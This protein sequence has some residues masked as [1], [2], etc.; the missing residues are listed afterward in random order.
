ML[1]LTD[2]TVMV[3]DGGSQN[4]ER[5]TPDAKGR[6]E[7][8]T[9]TALAPMSLA[10]LYF[11]S[12][13]LPS[14]K[15][16][17]LG[18]EYSGPGLPR[19][20]TNVAEI[21][22]PVANSWT[23]AAPYPNVPPGTCYEKI[24]YAGNTTSGSDVITGI[25]STARFQVGWAV[26]GP[27]IPAGATITSIDSPT[28]VHIS[29]NATATNAA[30]TLL[31]QGFEQSCFG[32]VPT[33][34]LPG[35][36]TILAGSL[37]DKSAYLYS[38]ASDSWAATGSKL[39]DKS[40]EEGYVLTS[41]GKVVTY[42]IFQS[43]A[44]GAGYAES[45]DPTTG[46]WSDISPGDGSA[47]G[48]LPLLSSAA[49]GDEFGPILR[50]QD[51]RIFAIGATNATAFYTAT[52][53]TWAA[54]PTITG[55]L[56]GNPAP[57]GADDAPGAILPNGHVLFAADA[58]PAA[59]TSTGNTTAGSNVITN[60]PSTALF[61]VGWNVTQTDGLSNVIPPNTTITSVDSPSQIHI[62]NNALTTNAGFGLKFGGTF[63]RPT[64]LFD[65]N[66]AGG[67]SISPV[68]PA[69]ADPVL[70]GE[71]SYN[72][73]M[74][75]LP[76]GQVLFSDSTNQL[77]V[78]T[79]DGVPKPKLRPVINNIAYNGGGVFTLT[80]KQLNGQSAGADYGDDVQMDSNYPILRLVS[81]AGDVY[82][83]RTYNWSKVAVGTSKA[84]E[85]VNF[86]LNSALP[87][88]NY[89]A[90]VSGAGISSFPV[91]VNIT[92]AEVN[93]Q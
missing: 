13:I 1:L 53:N 47:A 23:P 24:S 38:I 41:D 88:G 55:T 25:P 91:F 62:S 52:S 4:W 5:L 89:S 7:F 3:Q 22:D 59:V 36:G 11:A 51:G 71:G 33:I 69:L 32:A 9:W 15:L 16:W 19:T 8:G 50:L 56:N 58:G 21:Y 74:V 31:F 42:D 80:G 90:V 86:T 26:S 65:F 39:F 73:R 83:C 10:R 12:Q 27:G 67:G 76:T 2:G 82:Y 87:A 72:T 78:Y 54:G 79:G 63:S 28:Q 75:L 49:L 37:V 34:L 64:Q 40:D 29:V 84:R 44:K 61:Q 77:Y 17:V 92:Q 43:V 68:A 20:D 57:F 46:A 35:G 45:Y 81:R 18:G 66:P 6:Y 14:G 30:V 93:G 85:T 70:A 60:I 48:D